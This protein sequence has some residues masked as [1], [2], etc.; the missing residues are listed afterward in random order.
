MLIPP[1]TVVVYVLVVAAPFG[2][3]VTAYSIGALT[4]VAV[5]A[6]L[7]G[8]LILLSIGLPSTLV[9]AALRWD[10]PAVG[11]TEGLAAGGV[12]GWLVDEGSVGLL[13]LHAVTGG[14]CGA[15][16]TYVIRARRITPDLGKSAYSR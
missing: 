10:H 6:F 16:A 1:L 3:T 8:M 2:A 13:T 5:A 12:F 11:A 14:L 4:S 9:L 15:V 7:Y